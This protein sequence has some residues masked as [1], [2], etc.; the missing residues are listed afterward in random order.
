MEVPKRLKLGDTSV[1]LRMQNAMCN[2][3]TETKGCVGQ[4]CDNCILN[5]VLL[6]DFKSWLINTVEGVK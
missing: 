3:E 6:T 4:D 2:Y 1:I 5:S